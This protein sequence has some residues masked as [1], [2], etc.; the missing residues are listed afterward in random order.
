MA[1]WKRSGK[2]SKAEELRRAH[3]RNTNRRL[4]NK[5]KK[6]ER[7]IKKHPNELQA[8]ESLKSYQK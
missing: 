1:K 6:I 5:V 7:Y 3:Y 4:E 8:Q 2:K